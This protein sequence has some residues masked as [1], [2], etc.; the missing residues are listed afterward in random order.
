MSVPENRAQAAKA[1]QMA[2][3]VVENG[4]KTRAKRLQLRHLKN[5]SRGALA[6]PSYSEHA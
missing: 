4:A 2:R 3:K 1:A 5:I 6:N